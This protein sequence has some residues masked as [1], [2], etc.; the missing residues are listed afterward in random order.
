MRS[1]VGF[2]YIIK[3]FEKGGKQVMARID[4]RFHALSEPWIIRWLESEPGSR[5]DR[6]ALLN[7]YV[8][9]IIRELTATVGRPKQAR[10]RAQYSPPVFDWR[11]SDDLQLKY[12]VRTH[13]S[14]LGR[15]T[16][17]ITILR[18]WNPRSDSP[19]P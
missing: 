18:L 11:F 3:S 17:R 15:Q 1:F 13:Q 19:S 10:Q 5:E 8:S 16:V 2:V 12:T 4:V 14:L 6:K 7:L 9:E